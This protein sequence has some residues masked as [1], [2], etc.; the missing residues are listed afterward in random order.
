MPCECVFCRDA[1]EITI[2]I[3]TLIF[4]MF[5]FGHTSSVRPK[6]IYYIQ[7]VNFIFYDHFRIIFSYNKI[8]GSRLL[9]GDLQPCKTRF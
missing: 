5:V 2:I 9:C 1:C 3:I 6:H 8:H 7:F 4:V